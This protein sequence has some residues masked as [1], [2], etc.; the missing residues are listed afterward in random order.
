MV[1]D[2]P[3][4]LLGHLGNDRLALFIGLLE[5]ARKLCGGPQTPVSCDGTESGGRPC[6]TV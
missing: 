5:E 4:E 3:H 2:S 6:P 1:L